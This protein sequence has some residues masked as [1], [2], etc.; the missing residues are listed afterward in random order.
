VA[1]TT[2]TPLPS[3]DRAATRRGRRAGADIRRARE[4]ENELKVDARF[5]TRALDLTANP[6]QTAEKAREAIG[7]SL[8]DQL[9][10]TR[11]AHG[12][13]LPLRERRRPTGAKIA[14]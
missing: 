12:F 10:S 7:V 9:A 5:Q 1:K 8:K 6:Q 4:L 11:P 2:Q 13:P 3:I 14:S